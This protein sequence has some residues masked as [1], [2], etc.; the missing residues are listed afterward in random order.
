MQ[1]TLQPPVMAQF[2]IYPNPGTKLRAN[3]QVV[4]ILGDD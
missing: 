1:S 2:Q 4:E 3:D